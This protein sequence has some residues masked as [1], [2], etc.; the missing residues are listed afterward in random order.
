[1]QKL[2]GKYLNFL[3]RFEETYPDYEIIIDQ[4]GW[5]SDAVK[6]VCRSHGELLSLKKS[7]IF[8]SKTPCPSCNEDIRVSLR[9]MSKEEF[10]ERSIKIH[11][12]KYDYSNTQVKGCRENITIYCNTCQEYFDQ[13]QDYHLAGNGCQVCA[14][15]QRAITA[16]DKEY[17]TKRLFFT[18]EEVDH[19]S[20]K[21]ED[22]LDVVRNNI[23]RKSLS[24]CEAVGYTKL[25]S[26]PKSGYFYECVCGKYFFSEGKFGESSKRLSCGCLKSEKV[27]DNA[28][29]NFLSVAK[30]RGFPTESF[31]FEDYKSDTLKYNCPEHGEVSLSNTL[32][33]LKKRSNICHKCSTEVAA[34]SQRKTLDEI[35]DFLETYKD[36][37]Y[38]LLNKTQEY[39]NTKSHLKF[40]CNDTGE[41]FTM[42]Y[43]NL[44]SGKSCP[45]CSNIRG[46]KRNLSGYI[47]VSLWLSETHTHHVKVGITNLEPNKRLRT[48][49]L[50]SPDMDGFI[51]LQLHH[52]DGNLIYNLE[53]T[54]GKVFER[55]EVDRNIFGDG[56][57]ECYHVKDLEAIIGFIEERIK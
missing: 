17:S 40:V 21:T 7:S 1:M 22:L 11:G 29:N 28:F 38:S 53:Q 5:L 19:L 44:V 2:H 31:T 3:K 39:F 35:E 18:K 6:I 36:G 33:V 25:E 50:N 14:Q 43:G 32:G 4:E 45:C 57:S 51:V 8:K 48:Q 46:Y 47:Y 23:G 30:E 24:G 20:L 34:S 49:C 12:D 16:S 27:K 13:V 37:K 55:V 15:K 10:I 26:K 52:E 54:V 9:K 41:N 42:A 56:F